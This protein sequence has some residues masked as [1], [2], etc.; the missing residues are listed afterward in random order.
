MSHCTDFSNLINVIKIITAS[1]S[2]LNTFP[3]GSIHTNPKQ[4][5]YLPSLSE[6]GFVIN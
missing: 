2:T 3:S 6:L 5:L 1:A 4:S